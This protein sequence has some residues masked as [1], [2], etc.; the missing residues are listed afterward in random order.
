[1]CKAVKEHA[2]YV[3]PSFLPPK[4]KALTAVLCFVYTKFFLAFFTVHKTNRLEERPG[5]DDWPQE[6][7]TDS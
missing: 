6:A 3:E 5:T 7:I 1:M 4:P 2:T